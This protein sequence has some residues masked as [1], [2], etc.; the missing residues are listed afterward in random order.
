MFDTMN[1]PN[2]NMAIVKAVRKRECLMVCVWE[3]NPHEE[4][5]QNDYYGETRSGR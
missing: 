4:M 5:N 1:S 3:P 2:R